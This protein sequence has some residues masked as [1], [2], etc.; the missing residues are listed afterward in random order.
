[1]LREVGRFEEAIGVGQNVAA[2]F[3][4]T[5]DRHGEALALNNLGLALREI[6]RF[7]EAISAHR[8]AI[9]IFRET[10]DRHSEDIAFQNLELDRTTQAPKSHREAMSAAT[11][12]YEADRYKR[13][14]RNPAVR[15]RFCPHQRKLAMNASVTYLCSVSVPTDKAQGIE[16]KD[17]GR[18][19]V[20]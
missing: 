13:K 15:Y 7:E 5:G 3:R 10:G 19:P 9:A 16:V 2:I 6:R 12:L 8:D 20:G 4:E 1:M 11:A 17:R 18:L 14:V